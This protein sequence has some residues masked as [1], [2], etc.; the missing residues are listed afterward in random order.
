MTTTTS[1]AARPPQ[2]HCAGF[3]PYPRAIVNIASTAPP[4]HIP[5]PRMPFSFMA[6]EYPCWADA[7]VS[8]AALTSHSTTSIC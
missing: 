6:T 7:R 2:S 3:D 8:P 1:A 5:L 4:V